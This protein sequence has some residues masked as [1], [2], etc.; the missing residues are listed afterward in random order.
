[1]DDLLGAREAGVAVLGEHE[2]AVGR[3]VEDAVRAFDE[4][5]LDPQ[6]LPDLGRQTD[7]S[8]QV[9]SGH[10]VGDGDFHCPI[11]R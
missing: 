9:I 5:G 6:C 1:M 3:D 2:P 7:G 11:V 4:L 8:R 10:A